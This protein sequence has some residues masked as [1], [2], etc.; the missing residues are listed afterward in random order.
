MLVCVD[1]IYADSLFALNFIADWALLLA[2]GRLSGAVLRRWRIALAAALG[3]AY[4]LASVAPGWGFLTHPAAKI[5]LGVGMSL[6]AFGSERRFWR[7]CGMFFAVSALFGGAVWGAA[8]LAGYDAARGVYVPVSGRVLA[9]SFALLYVY[10]FPAPGRAARRAGGVSLEVSLAG[11]SVALR[12][13]VDSGDALADPVSGRRAAVAEG[14]APWSRSPARCRRG[15]GR[16]R[17]RGGALAPAR[18]GG[19]G[20]APALPRRGAEEDCSPA[21]RP[22][23]VPRLRRGARTAGGPVPPAAGRLGRNSAAARLKG[24]QCDV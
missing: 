22:E 23:R 7:C 16:R 13:L 12:A 1:T 21:L 20:A 19:E 11:R 5:A 15:A 18:A 9:L 10:L 4:A 6:I 3:A 24:G 2:A 14:G 17:R 8:M